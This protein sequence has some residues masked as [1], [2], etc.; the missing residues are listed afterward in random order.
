MPVVLAAGRSGILLHEAIGHGMEADFNRKGI[1][2]YADQIGKA[3]GRADF[4][5]IVDDGTVPGRAR[6]ASTSTTRATPG[7][8]TVLVEN[9][10]LRIATCTTAI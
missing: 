10:I 3:G 5:T 9:G 8:R 6:L 7:Q 4:V 1:S 2:I